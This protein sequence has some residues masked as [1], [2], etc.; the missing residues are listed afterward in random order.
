MINISPSTK[1]TTTSHLKF[2]LFSSTVIKIETI[3]C[4]GKNRIRRGAVVSEFIF[5]S[6]L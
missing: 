2:V 5:I 6:H 1:R 3:F 4:G